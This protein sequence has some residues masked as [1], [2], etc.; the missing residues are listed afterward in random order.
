MTPVG[1]QVF[2]KHTF[3]D[4]S[5][6]NGKL[7]F[8]SGEEQYCFFFSFFHFLIA[9]KVQLYFLFIFDPDYI[10]KTNKERCLETSVA[11]KIIISF[12]AMQKRQTQSQ[13]C[14]RNVYFCGYVK[15]AKFKL[16]IIVSTSEMD[17]YNHLRKY[18]WTGHSVEKH[19]NKTCACLWKERRSREYLKFFS[20]CRK[21]TH[22]SIHTNTNIFLTYNIEMKFLTPCM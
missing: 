5:V 7:S 17:I 12:K 8:E 13:L 2:H 21:L 19:N 4:I 14:H 9:K 10:M 6:L 18:S 15:F 1:S 22:A 11:S 20:E 3:L 16:W